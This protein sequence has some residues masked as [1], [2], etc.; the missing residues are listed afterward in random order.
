[1]KRE[2]IKSILLVL[3]FAVS[4]VLTQ[5]LWFYLP[6][7]GM[8]S[9]ANDIELEDIHID[10]TDILS[11]QNFVISF[12]GGDYA[13]FFSEPYEVW[14]ITEDTKDVSIWETA[15]EVLR[16]YL[17][18]DYEIQEVDY[19]EWKKIRKFKSIRMNFACEIPGDSLAG[20]L[21]GEGSDVSVIK[22]KINTILILAT[23]EQEIN[24]IYFGNDKQNIYFK[25][26]SSVTDN[27]IRG[28]IENIEEIGNEKGYISSLPLK[29]HSGVDN[30]VFTPV[31]DDETSESIPSYSAKNQIDVS[32]KLDVKNKAYQFFGRTFDFVKEINE[33]DGTVIYMY[34]YGEKTLKLSKDGTL[35]YKE[36]PSKEK[37]GN[38][39]DFID[40]LKYAAKFVEDKVKWPVNIK[41]AYLSD[42]KTI[43]ADNKMGYV[44]SFNYRLKG[45]SVFIPDT[46]ED[47]GIQVEIIGNQITEYTR[48]VKI[49]PQKLNNEENG[50]FSI[51]NNDQEKHILNVSEV[52][53]KNKDDIKNNYIKFSKNEVQEDE[54]KD[55]NIEALIQDIGLVYYAYEDKLIPVWEITIDDIV[56]YF[57]LYTG[58]NYTS[59][60]KN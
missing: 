27:R 35:V 53:I 37:A 40:S 12:G 59:S 24:N 4:L 13:T 50:M 18:K 22:D 8:I 14:N 36:K 10:V 38:N 33:I 28:L 11:P 32:D 48:I 42:Y 47:K 54:I 39:L 19:D 6:F 20:A 9:T 46:V 31:F 21:S 1:M 7:G 5:R 57:D 29:Y 34:G 49:P 3:L 17:T 43:E 41:N 56:Y 51:S 2:N 16:D 23:N 30:D 55:F 60:K 52:L 25:V 26:K 44:F 15:K 58:R 45:L